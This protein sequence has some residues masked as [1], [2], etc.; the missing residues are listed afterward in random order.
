M[1]RR[2]FGNIH[3]FYDFRSWGYNT[4]VFFVLQNLP[5]SRNGQ[6]DFAHVPCIFV[7][8]SQAV[9]DSKRQKRN[10][11]KGYG[12][13]CAAVGTFLPVLFYCSHNLSQGNP[14]QP[15]WHKAVLY[16]SCCLF[17]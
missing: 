5:N 11:E 6:A 7:E 13:V 17:C 8:L 3:Q 12:L 10:T 15:S 4:D 9:R 1:K 14:F 2:L 16:L